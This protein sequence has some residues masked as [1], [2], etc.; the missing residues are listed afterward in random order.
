M[1]KIFVHF[2]SLKLNMLIKCSLTPLV[3]INDPMDIEDASV[4]NNDSKPTV[5]KS[6]ESK[7][8]IRISSTQSSMDSGNEEE[9]ESFSQKTSVSMTLICRVR[10]LTT[11]ANQLPNTEKLSRKREN[12]ILLKTKM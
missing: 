4:G 6:K 3:D 1:S 10:R 8:N 2:A 11:P 12:M 7:R 9:I 5:N